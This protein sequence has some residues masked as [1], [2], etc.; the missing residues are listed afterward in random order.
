L[1]LQASLP[2]GWQAVARDGSLVV[3]EVATWIRP[4]GRGLHLQA[5]LDRLSADRER[6]Q[7]AVTEAESAHAAA[8]AA[9][10]TARAALAAARDREAA[11][12][13]ARRRADEIERA[14]TDRADATA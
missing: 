5:D 11:T 13:A 1:D 10:A 3:G 6:A 7:Q 14:A 8:D 12:A 9:L 4:D 2:A